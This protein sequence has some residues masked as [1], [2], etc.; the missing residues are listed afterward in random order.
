MIGLDQY[1]AY[2]M[3]ILNAHADLMLKALETGEPYPSRWASTLATT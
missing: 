2:C 3:I 1:P